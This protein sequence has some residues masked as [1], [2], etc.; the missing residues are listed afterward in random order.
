MREVLNPSR[1]QGS[2]PCVIR[3][4]P[5]LAAPSQAPSNLVVW[6]VPSLLLR[7]L[8]SRKAILARIFPKE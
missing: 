2:L 7:L 5:T 8:S 6:L 4:Q 3:T 1:L